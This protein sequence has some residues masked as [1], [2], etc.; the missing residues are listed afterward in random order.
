MDVQSASSSSFT[1]QDRVTWTDEAM[2]DRVLQR[3]SSLSRSNKVGVGVRNLDSFIISDAD[4]RS[5]DDSQFANTT[6]YW[7]YASFGRRF[8]SDL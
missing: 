2:T 8:G 1:N 7:A 6:G 4:T 5:T 3:L